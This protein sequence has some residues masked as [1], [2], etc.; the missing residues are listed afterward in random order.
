MSSVL[1]TRSSGQ[2]VR[3]YIDAVELPAA[4]DCTAETEA[5][6][7]MGV[8]LTPAVRLLSV[9]SDCYQ[10][11]GMSRLIEVLICY[12][13]YQ[14]DGMSR[15]K[16]VLMCYQCYQ[17]DG[18]SRLNEVLICY[19]CYQCDGTS[20]LNEVLICYQYYQCDGMSR[21]NEV[22]ICDTVQIVHN[23]SPLPR[24]HPSYGDCLEVKREYYQ[25]CSVLG[26]VTQCSQSA[27]HSY[28][29]FL[30]VQQ[31]GFVTL[32]PLRRA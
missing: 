8:S 9:L 29:Q 13:Y 10:C 30:H 27:A 25:N 7:R 26:C 17:C 32:G 19:Q 24:Q 16:E 1:S 21:L 28:E 31:I 11:D 15:L 18:T 20:R 23:W 2:H 4:G 3:S 6:V 14:C 22:L 5:G 12:Q